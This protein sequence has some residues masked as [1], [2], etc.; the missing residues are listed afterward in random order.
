[1]Q[2]FLL[3]TC[4]QDRARFLLSYRS[5]A[6]SASNST[7]RQVLSSDETTSGSVP[8]L[9]KSVLFIFSDDFEGTID[10]VDYEGAVDSH[11]ELPMLPKGESYEEIEYTITAGSMRII[12]VV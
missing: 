8:A 12:M 11:L 7:G 3:R 2:L 4:W 6:L 5:L 9:A 10:A 1:L